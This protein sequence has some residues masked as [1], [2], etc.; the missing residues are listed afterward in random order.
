M[1]CALRC[2]FTLGAF[3]QRGANIINFFFLKASTASSSRAGLWGLTPV[4]EVVSDIVYTQLAAVRI[5][6][7][8]M[9]TNGRYALIWDALFY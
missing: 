7:K 5:L 4:F 8:P 2:R 6:S 3:K 1:L 9:E